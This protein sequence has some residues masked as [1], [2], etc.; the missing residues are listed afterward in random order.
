LTFLL[1]TNV[2]SETR[3]VRRDAGVTRWIRNT[4]PERVHLSVITVGEIVRGITKLRKRRDHRQVELFEVWL[5]DVIDTFGGRIVPVTVDVATGWGALSGR[6]ISDPDA[7]IA[8]TAK[9]HGW[10]VVTR[11]VKD[12]EP[13][14]VACLNP[15][16][17][18]V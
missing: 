12:F 10:T 3:K 4:P 13:T 9:V 8:A 14:G 2:L 7:L 15:F 17:G 6:T 5:G 11:N 16:S 18:E 1:D